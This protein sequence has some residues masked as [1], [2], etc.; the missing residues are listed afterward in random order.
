[1]N[2]APQELLKEKEELG[3]ERCQLL[4]TANASNYRNIYTKNT[5]KTQLGG[6]KIKVHG[7]RN[8]SFEP[9][10]IGEYR[11]NADGMEEKILAL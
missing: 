9:K 11:W 10:I 5:V 3:R 8:G 6:V 2:T 7:D 1:M 4:K